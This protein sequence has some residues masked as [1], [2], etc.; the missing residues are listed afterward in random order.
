[1]ENN[2]ESLLNFD[3]EKINYLLENADK[4]PQILNKDQIEKLVS[5]IKIDL[6]KMNDIISDLENQQGKNL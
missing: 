4:I 5:L 2:P 1:M 3:E 6:E